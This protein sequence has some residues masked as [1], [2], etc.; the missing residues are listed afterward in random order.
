L[1]NLNDT[2]LATGFSAWIKIGESSLTWE[3]QTTDLNCLNSCPEKNWEEYLNCRDKCIL[4]QCGVFRRADEQL[5]LPH[6][7]GC[8]S[9]TYNGDYSQVLKGLF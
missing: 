4:R 5:V 7:I 1:A 8:Q 3:G 2:L 6:A 9:P